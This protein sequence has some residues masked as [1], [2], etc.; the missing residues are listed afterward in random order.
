MRGKLFNNLVTVSWLLA[1]GSTI[2]SASDEGKP[3]VEK[4]PGQGVSKSLQNMSIEDLRIEVE[5]RKLIRE[6]EDAE[7][8]SSHDKAM[9]HLTLEVSTRRAAEDADFIRKERVAGLI[10]RGT[11]V[12]THLET[13]GLQMQMDALK[14]REAERKDKLARREGERS[15]LGAIKDKLW[16]N[17]DIERSLPSVPDHV[18]ASKREAE[19][20]RETVRLMIVDQNTLPLSILDVDSSKGSSSSS[21]YEGKRQQSSSSS[22]SS[23]NKQEEEVD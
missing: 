4:S 1:L 2:V 7:D 13:H 22:S 18:G 21:S 23:R 6:M 16:G 14:L 10:E 5:R 8:K 12:V 9:R 11:N 20:V 3:G 17:T 15:A 19:S